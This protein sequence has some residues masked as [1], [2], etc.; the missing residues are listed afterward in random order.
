MISV[1]RGNVYNTL[2]IANGTDYT[3]CTH[4]IDIV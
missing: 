3:N 2:T 4:A 1:V